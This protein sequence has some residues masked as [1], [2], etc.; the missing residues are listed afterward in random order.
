MAQNG[1]PTMAE[2]ERVPDVPGAG[3]LESPL[4]PATPGP[5]AAALPSAPTAGAP[6]SGEMPAAA[7]PDV[8]AA[9]PAP[10]EP[11]AAESPAAEPP[12][13]KAHPAKPGKGPPQAQELV[14]SG[15]HWYVLRVASNKEDR[16]REALERKVKIEQLDPYV[17][18]VLVPTQRERRVRGGT[19][20]VYH[21]KLYPGYVFVE[22]ATDSDGR[23]PENVWFVIKETTG[24]G[25]FIGSGGKP[26]PMPLADV[27]KMLAAAIRPDE[28]AALANLTFKKGDKVKV[29]EGPFENFEGTVDE[30]NTEKGTVRV[31]LTIF[32]R[33]TP[34]DIE[35]WR[36]EQV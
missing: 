20:R 22:M 7:P 14:R 23:I 4:D 18:R 25:D 8:A 5:A 24:V 12:A 13:E 29:T 26:S 27:E 6:G 15:M 35:Y 21:R 31:I 3:A 19:S 16:V 28:A 32:G 9:N 11:R 1:A 36:L 30:I 2:D 10:A 17:G 34:V 33:P